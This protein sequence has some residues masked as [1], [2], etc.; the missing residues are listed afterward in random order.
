MIKEVNNTKQSNYLKPTNNLY[1]K[2]IFL[3]LLL[4]FLT[5]AQNNSTLFPDNDLDDKNDRI[6]TLRTIAGIYYQTKDYDSALLTYEKIL[7]ERANDEEALYMKGVIFISDKNY[8]KAVDHLEA[9]IK[10]NSDNYHNYNN[11]AWLYATAD[12]VNF[13]N[14][15]KSLDLSLK[16][17]VLAPYDKHIWSTLA[18]AYFISGNFIKAKRAMQQV[19]A[20]ATQDGSKLTEDMVKI[21]NSQIEKFERAIN[22]Q[23]LIDLD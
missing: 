16:A 4:P 9:Q 10:L 20:L 1:M 23:K 21:Y 18:E 19:V 13:R 15:K 3:I 11:L 7:Q 2:Q 22:T 5:F 14:A 17:L 8:K 12:D 6:E